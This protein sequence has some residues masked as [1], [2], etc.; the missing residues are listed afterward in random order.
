LERRELLAADLACQVAVPPEAMGSVNAAIVQDQTQLA[1]EVTAETTLQRRE[2]SEANQGIGA[3][4]RPRDRTSQDA[5]SALS[6]TLAT[7]QAADEPSQER[8]RTDEDSDTGVGRQK[9]PR[10]RDSEDV[11]AGSDTNDTLAVTAQAA[12][13]NGGT[14]VNPVNNLSEEEAT[15]LVFIREEEKLARDVYITLGEKWN[16]PIFANIAESE[17]RHMDAVGQLIEKYDLD[18]PVNDDTV[19]VFSN[20]ELQE[21]YDGLV[22]DDVVDLEFLNLDLNIQGGATSVLAALK[23]G[24]FIEEFDILDLQDA[25]A[26]TTQSDIENVY[27]NLLRGSRDHLRSFVG[28]IEATGETYEPV[29]MTGDLY[30]LYQEIISGDKETANGNGRGGQQRGGRRF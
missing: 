4:E 25:L 9:R 20:P 5:E 30:S 3:L 1:N 11:F 19:G 22:S 27:E 21:L 24:A 6:P 13:G 26:D 29:L 7:S 16:L 15:R 8:Q 2:R 10:D 17:Q 28:Q 18:D 23:V 12:K 14:Q